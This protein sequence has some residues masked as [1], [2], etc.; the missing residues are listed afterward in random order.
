MTHV[1]H[2]GRYMRLSADFIGGIIELESVLQA[3]AP[4]VADLAP[5]KIKHASG[6]VKA[7]AAN[8]KRMKK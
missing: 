5:K 2:K 4:S 8:I 7:R 6:P 1:E 3:G